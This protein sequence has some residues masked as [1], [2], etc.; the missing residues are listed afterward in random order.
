MRALLVA[1]ILL[2]AGCAAP[3][4]DVV[5]PEPEPL[6]LPDEVLIEASGDMVGGVNEGWIFQVDPRYQRF[7]ASVCVG[8]IESDFF[9]MHDYTIGLSN[10]NGTHGAVEEGSGNSIRTGTPMCLDFSVRPGD[11]NVTGDW[12]VIVDAAPSAATYSV[13]VNVR[14]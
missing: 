8:G 7:D 12:F 5:V 1:S 3:V 4:D 11:T 10:K 14:Y 9:V 13:Y 6:P 2:L